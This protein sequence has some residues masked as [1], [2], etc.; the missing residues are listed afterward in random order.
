MSALPLPGT[1]GAMPPA[2]PF[3]FVPERDTR[4]TDVFGNP[5]YKNDLSDFSQKIDEADK[6]MNELQFLVDFLNRRSN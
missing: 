5:K 4:Y 3:I 6:Q 1:P 2:K